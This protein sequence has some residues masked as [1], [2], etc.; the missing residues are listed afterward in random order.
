MENELL[1]KVVQPA[2]GVNLL[3][4]HV[5]RHTTA[6]G[7]IQG[8]QIGIEFVELEPEPRADLDLERLQVFAR[9]EAAGAG[10]GVLVAFE[11]L[12]QIEHVRISSSID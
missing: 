3:P 1:Q 7:H 12:L 8:A 10:L 11:T 5:L 9:F 6:H 4:A 2:I